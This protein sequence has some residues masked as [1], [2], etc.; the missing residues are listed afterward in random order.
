MNEC[1][2]PSAARP[3]ELYPA[4][5]LVGR[6]HA[7]GRRSRHAGVG[8]ASF[9]GGVAVDDA[10]VAVAQVSGDERSGMPW[11]RA[12]VANPGAQ[13]VGGLPVCG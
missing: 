12:S 7:G 6:E 11:A 9:G 3:A 2:G 4:A 1:R 5:R 8:R 10:H 13:A